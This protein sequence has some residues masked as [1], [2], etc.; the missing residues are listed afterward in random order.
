MPPKKKQKATEEEFEVKKDYIPDFL[1][2]LGE[3]ADL[4]EEEDDFR[5]TA[6]RRAIIALEGQII[7]GV[8]D[9]K[10]FV[11]GDLNGVGKGILGMLEEFIENGTIQRLEDLRPEEEEPETVTP[12][13]LMSLFGG[14]TEQQCDYMYE[15]W[16]ES[17]RYTDFDE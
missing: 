13:G 16:M 8:E 4:Y 15:W 9:I 11:L 12:E 17:G 1:L 3:L 7:T 2:A 10:L 5:A 6:M 14:M